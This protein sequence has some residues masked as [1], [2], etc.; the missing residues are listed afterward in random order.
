MCNT[1]LFI[2]HITCNSFTQADTKAYKIGLVDV[3][4]D[5]GSGEK[6]C[7]DDNTRCRQRG[8]SRRRPSSPELLIHLFF[9]NAP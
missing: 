9:A 1:A 6:R 8:C 5:R 7:D 3:M 2:K 4:D